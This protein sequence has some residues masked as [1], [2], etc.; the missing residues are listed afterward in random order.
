MSLARV[1]EAILPQVKERT[2]PPTMVILTYSSHSW[3]RFS[4]NRWVSSLDGDRSSEMR[5][6]VSK[7]AQRY[8]QV[9]PVR[10]RP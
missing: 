7:P 1:G 8:R 4:E 5:L 9:F 6:P 2:A 3:A 10:G